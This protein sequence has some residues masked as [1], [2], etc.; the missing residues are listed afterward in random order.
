MSEV[1]NLIDFQTRVTNLFTPFDPDS[2][3]HDAELIDHTLSYN[4]DP[5]A[6]KTVFVVSGSTAAAQLIRAN[7]AFPAGFVFVERRRSD[8][9][10]NRFPPTRIP[11]ISGNPTVANPEYF[12][13]RSNIH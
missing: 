6:C 10:F 8:V 4:F 9:V 13:F 5:C 1:P 11:P 7:N 3:Q 12:R 2:W